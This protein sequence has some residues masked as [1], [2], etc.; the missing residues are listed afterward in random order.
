MPNDNLNDFADVQAAKE[1]FDYIGERLTI[2]VKQMAEANKS[3][4]ISFDNLADTGSLTELNTQTKEAAKNYQS[5]AAGAKGYTAAITQADQ[6]ISKYNGHSVE[7]TQVLK[8][9][10]VAQ[11]TATQETI[12]WTK[13]QER[14]AVAD[15]KALETTQAQV[16]SINEARANVKLYTKELDNLNL[17]TEAGVIRQKQLTTAIN[18]QNAFIKTN[19]DLL[20]QQKINIGNYPEQFASTLASIGK[21]AIGFLGIQAGMEFISGISEEFGK[22]DEAAKKLENTLE[23][24]GAKDAIGRINEEAEKLSKTFGYLEAHDVKDVFSQLITYGKL[25]EDQMNELIPVVI[26]FAAKQKISVQESASVIVK[27]LEGSG[28]AL[29]EYGINIKDATSETETA[30]SPAERLSLIMKELKP[31]VEGAAVAFGSS[32]SG[33]VATW[34]K[35][36]HEIEEGVANFFVKLSGIEEQNQRNAITAHKEATEMQA[37][38]DEYKNLS[39]KVVKTSA[40]KNR[41]SEITTDLINKYGTSISVINEET[42]AIELNTEALKAAIKTRVL[43]SDKAAEAEERNY[44]RASDRLKELDEDR[45]KLLLARLKNRVELKTGSYEQDPNNLKDFIPGQ[46]QA[47][48]QKRLDAERNYNYM[49]DKNLFAQ[50]DFIVKKEESLKKLAELGVK[51]ADLLGLLNPTAIKPRS[52]LNAGGKSK[53]ETDNT[54]KNQQELTKALYDEYAKRAQIEAE[55]QKMISE[56]ETKS[57]AE[58]INAYRQYASMTFEAQSFGIAAEERNLQESLTE[59]ERIEGI[60][61]NKRTQQEKDL[62]AKKAVFQQQLNTVSAQYDLL[63]AQDVEKTAKG[64]VAIQQDEAKKRLDAIK[65]LTA[66]ID[67]QEAEAQRDLVAKLKAGTISYDTYT[68]QKKEIDDKFQKEKYQ[69]I[70]DYL[71]LE[72]AA[73][74]A[75]GVDTVDLQR[76][77]NAAMKSL[78]D[79]DVK[80]VED[81]AKQK[82]SANKQLQ[83]KIKEAVSEGI[84]LAQALVDGAYQKQL[85]QEQSKLDF[86]EQNKQAQLDAINSSME[87]DEV[88]AKQTKALNAQVALEEKQ[89]QKEMARIKRDQAIADRV[90]AILRVVENTAIAISAAISIPIVGEALAIADAAIGAAQVGVILATPLPQYR[91]GVKDH[92]GGMAILGDGFQK[93]VVLE[94]GKAPYLSSDQPAVYDLA[95]HTMVIPSQEELIANSLGFLTPSLLQSLNL[96]TNDYSKLQDATEQGFSRLEQAINNKPVPQWKATGGE[97]RKIVRRGNS[98]TE[99]LNDQF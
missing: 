13:E 73:L 51:E 85:Q 81:A 4:K 86:I 29:K 79:A 84:N 98:S 24:A 39:E 32:W 37:L 27:A 14:K 20:A 56:D 89:I 91:Y 6:I 65:N 2:F 36:V 12:L 99:Y 75:A 58:R 69:Q 16:G 49:L 18:E 15:K 34:K 19:K 59:I 38:A 67:I 1:Q 83:D 96:N 90:A 97:W 80:N 76:Q 26:N 3:A 63:R 71:N 60:S 54:L 22:A 53:T 68:K 40:D 23:N 25:S 7:Y 72:I 57:L 70:V 62:V 44:I 9:V 55:Y 78:Y 30:A 92:P 10:A 93:E 33:M 52:D 11:K 66:N 64:I 45:E 87:S 28:K 43:L 74:S 88:K 82:E 41:L 94:P 35:E 95:P 48:K 42:G 17:S 21:F 8:N 77:L 61:V 31:R 46:D 50:R 5:A 47:E